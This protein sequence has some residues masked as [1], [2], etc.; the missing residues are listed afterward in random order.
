MTEVFEATDSR[1][2]P[3]LRSVA[4]HGVFAARIKPGRHAVVVNISGAGVLVETTFR[5][6]PGSAVEVHLTAAAAHSTM[7][8]RVVRCVVARLCASA[9]WYQGAI[10]FDHRLA[11]FDRCPT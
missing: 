1:R 10:A 4:E 8:G 5:L 11:W 9:V 7:R 2:L 6:L 3:R